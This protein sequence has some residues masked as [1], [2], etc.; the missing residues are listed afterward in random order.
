[1]AYCLF[2]DDRML[3]RPRRPGEFPQK[4]NLSVCSWTFST[5]LAP[6]TALAWETHGAAWSRMTGHDREQLAEAKTIVAANAP[7]QDFRSLR[8]VS[9]NR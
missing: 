7:H 9:T 5:P 1:M 8:N 6:D 3:S 4:A 2:I